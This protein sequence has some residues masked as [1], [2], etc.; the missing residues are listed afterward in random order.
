M[1][2]GT[3]FQLKFSTE[4]FDFLEKNIPN[5]DSIINKINTVTELCIFKIV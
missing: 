3:K 2:V 1:I 5:F 4:N